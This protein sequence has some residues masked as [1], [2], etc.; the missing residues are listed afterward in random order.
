M[1]SQRERTWNGGTPSSSLALGSESV[2]QKLA[3][4][5]SDWP[6][7]NFSLEVPGKTG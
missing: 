5:T 1:T 2:T 3:N 7:L 4:W 6:D